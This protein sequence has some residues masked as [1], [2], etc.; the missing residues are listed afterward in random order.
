MGVIESRGMNTEAGLEPDMQTLESRWDI[1]QLSDV[2]L[3]RTLLAWT[4]SLDREAVFQSIE[5]TP[6][7]DITVELRCPGI[8]LPRQGRRLA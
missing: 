8:C 3:A 1:H 4:R 7:E 5:R 2:R 6:Y